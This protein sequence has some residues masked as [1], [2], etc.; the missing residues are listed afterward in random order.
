MISKDN[1][2]FL[3]ILAQNNNREWFGA[4]KNTYEAQLINTIDLADELLL[5]MSNHDNIKNPSGKKALMRIYR[6]VR[7]SK[8]KSPYKT[9]WGIHFKRATKQLRGGYYLHI[10][11]GNTFVAGG[12][13]N[14]EPSDLKLIRE[15]IATDEMELR[16]ILTDK[17]FIDVFGELGLHG[18]S[19]VSV[20]KAFDK[21]HS[22]GDLLKL[23][24]FILTKK[25]SDK[26]VLSS[27]FAKKSNEVFVAMRPLLNWMSYSLTHDG[28]GVSI[29]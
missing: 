7:F 13:W 8:N 26:E 15:A 9:H 10:E 1:F 11:P 17:K 21:S 3:K 6:D 24:Q 14:P 27:D 25:F 23:K 2:D 28:N 16:K 29:I 4:N 5:L 18:E 12:F 22:A 20:P 19:L